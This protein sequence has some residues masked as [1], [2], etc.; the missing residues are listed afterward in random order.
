MK[1]FIAL[2]L[3]ILLVLSLCACGQSA[4]EAAQAE[5]KLQMGFGRD[6][7]LFF[8]GRDKKGNRTV[9]AFTCDFM[10]AEIRGDNEVRGFA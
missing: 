3:A 7:V 4:E 1:K 8:I 9:A 6:A 2:T 5:I 10:N